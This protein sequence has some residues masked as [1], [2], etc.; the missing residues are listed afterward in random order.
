MGGSTRFAAGGV[1]ALMTVFGVS[2]GT[3]I[4]VAVG[5]SEGHVGAFEQVKLS[6][7]AG[8]LEVG[9]VPERVVVT[10][11]RTKLTVPLVGQNS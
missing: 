10:C 3:A 1:I 7:M 4:V 11:Q 6:V 2:M 9:A 5:D 8:A